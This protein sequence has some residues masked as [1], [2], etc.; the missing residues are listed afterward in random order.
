MNDKSEVFHL[1]VNFTEWFKH[2]LKVQL[3]DCVLIMEEEY[4]NQHLS[5]FLKENGVVHELTC[6]DTPQRNEVC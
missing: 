2:N 6:V 4:V 1:F 5:K 3:R